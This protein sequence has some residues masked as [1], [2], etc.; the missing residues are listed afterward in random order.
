MNKKAFKWIIGA[1]AVAIFVPT[2]VFMLAQEHKKLGVNGID[3]QEPQEIQMDEATKKEL[4]AMMEQMENGTITQEELLEQ[5]GVE[6]F[7][8]DK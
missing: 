8:M 2:V 5:L 4:D 1:L 6:G 7:D 3:Q